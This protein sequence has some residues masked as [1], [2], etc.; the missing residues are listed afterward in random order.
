MVNT[1]LQ[2]SE[3]KNWCLL[4]TR[5]LNAPTSHLLPYFFSPSF[6]VRFPPLPQLPAHLLPPLLTSRANTPLSLLLHHT[7]SLSS[8]NPIISHHFSNSTPS[9][10]PTP[11]FTPTSLPSL[12]FTSLYSFLFISLTSPPI[13]SHSSLPSLSQ[14][15]LPFSYF[16]TLTSPSATPSTPPISLS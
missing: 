7:F 12:L 2:N 9:T 1:L 3:Q 11:L 5:F 10:P 6:N 15:T 16:S 8:F 13:T 4:R 14:L